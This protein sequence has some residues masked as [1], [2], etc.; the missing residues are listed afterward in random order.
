MANNIIATVLANV[1]NRVA[2][3]TERMDNAVGMHAAK[4]AS[5]A[6]FEAVSVKDQLMDFIEATPISVGKFHWEC[7][8]GDALCTSKLIPSAMWTA[9]ASVFSKWCSDNG[10]FSDH[11]M[12]PAEWLELLNGQ[13]ATGVDIMNQSAGD[14]ETDELSL[15][16]RIVFSRAV[17]VYGLHIAHYKGGDFKWLLSMTDEDAGT[18]THILKPIRD[19]AIDRA[20]ETTSKRMSQLYRDFADSDEVA[21][22]EDGLQPVD[23]SIKTFKVWLHTPCDDGTYASRHERIVTRVADNKFDDFIAALA[24][25]D[26]KDITKY[27]KPWELIMASPKCHQTLGAFRASREYR[28]DVMEAKVKA[29]EAAEQRKALDKALDEREAAL[30]ARMI[31]LGL[32]EA[33]ASALAEEPKVEASQPVAPTPR[34]TSG[35]AGTNNMPRLNSRGLRH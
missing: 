30:N 16:E 4:A 26:L 31:A 2:K 33:P 1:N 19:W 14:G 10:V 3:A 27:G 24:G 21:T 11:H 6:H 18:T 17:F 34:I 28:I 29:I 32:M 12:T 9:Y 13:V 20:G 22:W 8:G 5:Q 15:E 35:I 23:L 25:G 7:E